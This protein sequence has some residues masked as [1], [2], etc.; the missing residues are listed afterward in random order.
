M[1]AGDYTGIDHQYKEIIR[2]RRWHVFV[3]LNINCGETATKPMLQ[4]TPKIFIHAIN[5][6]NK[7][8]SRSN[9]SN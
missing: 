1:V 6:C 5:M 3:S 9:D 7:I 8:D 2:C 4:Y